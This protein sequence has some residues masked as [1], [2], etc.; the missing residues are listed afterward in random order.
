MTRI[1]RSI[2]VCLV[3]GSISTILAAQICA[4]W[5]PVWDSS[6][7]TEGV[8][9]HQGRAWRIAIY[10]RTGA[11]FVRAQAIWDV[12]LYRHGQFANANRVLDPASYGSVE[13]LRQPPDPAL[14]FDSRYVATWRGWPLPALRGGLAIFGKDT[15]AAPRRSNS[16]APIGL[17][18]LQL[19]FTADPIVDDDFTVTPVHPVWTGF[20][21]DTGFYAVIWAIILSIVIPIWGM[22]GRKR[23]MWR[24]ATAVGLGSL[25]T[26]A[27]AWGCALWTDVGTGRTWTEVYRARVASDRF[28]FVQQSVAFGAAHLQQQDE[29]LGTF[30]RAMPWT[31]I[32]SQ[33]LSPDGSLVVTNVDA[34]GWPVTAL[35][36][37]FDAL[38]DRRIGQGR[39][40]GMRYGLVLGS[41]ASSAAGPLRTAKVLPLAPI[42][43]GFALDSVLYG[44]A[45]FALLI[46][47][48]VPMWLRAAGRR[49]RGECGHCGYDLRG[50]QHSCC[51]ECGA[52]SG[53]R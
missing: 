4:A 14:P 16:L 7:I 52:V 33:K 36:C 8:T 3:L 45:W 27:V 32:Q 40:E 49:C 12:A 1:I 15:P 19:L 13:L 46:L 37:Q 22:L 48:T 24:V 28:V 20:T 9:A 26:V 41:A 51:P 53:A 17:A 50:G 44:G 2:V 23:V 25:T 38:V 34:R 47:G 6:L 35:R 18:D 10:E 31:G 29:P 30:M 5:V 39:I 21:L 43:V 11:I 42:G